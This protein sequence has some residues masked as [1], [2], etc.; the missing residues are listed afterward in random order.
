MAFVHELNETR[1]I[2]VRV[3]LRGRDVGM[4]QQGLKHTKVRTAGKQVR[5]E[6]VAKNVRA[7]SVRGDPGIGRH[8]PNELEKTDAR[9]VRFA[10]REQPRARCR[11]V[12][13]PRLDRRRGT[14]GDGDQSFFRS[15]S[16]EDQKWLAFTN[17]GT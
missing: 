1:G 11:H 8:L 6:S 15:L 2:D 13:K 5:R 3:N 14:A 10:A 16:P 9:D 12:L 4:T 7:Y 17:R